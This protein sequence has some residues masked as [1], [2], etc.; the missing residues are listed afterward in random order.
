MTRERWFLWIRHHQ[1]ADALALGWV[2]APSNGPM[3][4]HDYC[5]LCEWLCDCPMVRPR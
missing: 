3:H 5:F 2:F 1:I 4:H